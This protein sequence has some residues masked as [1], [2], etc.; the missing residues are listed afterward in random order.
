MPGKTF[1]A[2][3]A[4]WRYLVEHGRPLLVE[5]PHLTGDHA[6]LEA[7][8]KQAQS[9]DEETQQLRGRRK[10]VYQLRR[11]AEV[12]GDELRARLAGALVHQFG[13]RSER[14][15]SFG[16]SPRPREIKRTS[17]AQKELAALKAQLEKVQSES[18]G[19]E[20]GSGPSTPA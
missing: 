12:K 14:L 7:V 15:I 13:P 6:A 20:P 3:M 19:E 17:P 5:A 16:V 1:A 11:E 8:Y 10:E 4:D 9:L 2:K 18:G